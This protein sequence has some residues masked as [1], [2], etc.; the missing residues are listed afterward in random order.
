MHRIQEH[1]DTFKRIVSPS[2]NSPMNLHPKGYIVSGANGSGRG[3]IVRH[4]ADRLKLRFH[5]INTE[6]FES[7]QVVFDEFSAKFHPRTIV[8][9]RNFD[10]H[11]DGSNSPFERRITHQLSGLIDRSKQ[12]FLP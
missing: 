12:A 10:I 8:L 5:E 4:V 2:I 6:P 1:A 11:L 7:S 9:L 3:F